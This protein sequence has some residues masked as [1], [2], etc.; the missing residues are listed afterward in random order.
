M[1]TAPEPPDY[2]E[3]HC[4]SNFTFL[5]GASHPAELVQRAW[6]LGYR[7][8]AITDECSMSGVVRAH[9]AAKELDIKLIIGS[10]FTLTDGTKLVALATDVEGYGNLCELITHGRRRAEKGSYELV[11]TDFV[12]GLPHCLILWVPD[13]VAD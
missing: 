4:V 9:L 8:I 6:E 7:A 1:A 10:E 11:R 5:R 3:L 2:A 12:D 13:R